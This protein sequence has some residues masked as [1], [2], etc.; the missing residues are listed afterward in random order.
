MIKIVIDEINY[1]IYAVTA[2]EQCTHDLLYDDIKIM[3]T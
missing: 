2:T 1:K 3:Q